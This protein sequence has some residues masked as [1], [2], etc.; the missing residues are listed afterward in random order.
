MSRSNVHACGLISFASAWAAEAGIAGLPA[1]ARVVR[2]AAAAGL[3]ECWLDGGPAW[4]PSE[5][6]RNEV[7]RLRG[8]MKVR[9]PGEVRRPP[10]AGRLLLI[11]GEALPTA[12]QLAVLDDADP[13]PGAPALVADAVDAAALT[14]L[15]R[16]ADPAITR[17]RY[18]RQA[19]AI[20]GATGKP[21]DGLVS[22]HINR[23]ISRVCTGLLLRVAG[24]RPFHATL[25]TAAL[26]G[27]MFASLVRHGEAGL[28]AGALLFQAASMFDGVDGEAARATF[29]SSHRGAMCDSLVD[30]AT[31]L[32]FVLGIVINMALR[33]HRQAADFGICGLLLLAA[34]LT[35]IGSRAR[36]SSAPFTFDGV[37]DRMR[38]R[39]TRFGQ[40]LIWLTM[41]DFLALASVVL[42]M[43]GW[44]EPALAAFSVVMAGWL[45]VVVASG[46]R[47]AVALR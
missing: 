47:Q 31:N 38:A 29:R 5:L 3:S 15:R 14:R 27:V 19:R 13:A 26:A 32:L 4:V 45:A 46:G 43:L 7:E 8:T 16:D 36:T 42:V 28:L 34:G 37:K 41:R 30:A 12:R 24:F 33:G 1:A 21:T 40:W 35:I 17:R 23:P 20:I 44:A 18:A 39:G 25:G 6:L 9:Y 22:R 2:E 11:A 10:A